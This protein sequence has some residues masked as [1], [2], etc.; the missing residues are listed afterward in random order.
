MG[1]PVKWFKI[2]HAK[3]HT[4]KKN[5]TAPSILEE[6][7]SFNKIG[8]MLLAVV[9]ATVGLWLLL[10]SRAATPSITDYINTPNKTGGQEVTVPCGTYVGGSASISHADW[11]VLK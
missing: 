8:F 11:L 10:L 4:K 9:F 3:P 7:Q 2:P 1:Q 6:A 5:F